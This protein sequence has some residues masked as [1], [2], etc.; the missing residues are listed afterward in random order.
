MMKDVSVQLFSE[1]RTIR[2][3]CPSK[4]IAARLFKLAHVIS[5]AIYGVKETLKLR[6]VPRLEIYCNGQQFIP[7]LNP[8]K[9]VQESFM[10]TSH[11]AQPVQNLI[12]PELDL[13][14]NE[15]YRNPHPIYLTQMSDQKVLFANPAAL[16]SNHRKAADLVGKEITAL[17]DDEV[18]T[19]LIGRLRRDREL[20]QYS[21]PGY[22]WSRDSESAIWRR[23]RYMFVANYKL[24][25]F[26]GAACRF[27]I[28]TSAEKL[29]T[30]MV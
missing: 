17:W 14:L 30:Q 6:F 25:E 9:L 8:E 5:L 24:V 13:D 28:I 27:C 16:I 12:L 20:W 11:E 3:A 4:K 22:R 1:A 2:F 15:L 18:L 29:Q 21:Y 23:D 19:Q 7:R 10:K 26:L